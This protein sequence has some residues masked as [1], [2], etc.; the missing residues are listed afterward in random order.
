VTSISQTALRRIIDDAQ[1]DGIGLLKTGMFVEDKT[2]L[3]SLL[4]QL[5]DAQKDAVLD[6]ATEHNLWPQALSL[7]SYLKPDMQILMS[8]LA[9][10]QP[11]KVLEKL[12]R[13]VYEQ[14]NWQP[15]FLALSVMN[16]AN[17]KRNASLPALQEPEI[18]RRLVQ[19][20]TDCGMKKEIAPLLSYLSAEQKA[21]LA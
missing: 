14:D 6:A 3:D 20:A 15:L 2:L 7:I 11:K 8:N 21:L 13:T 9:G 12:L 4:R 19:R 10:Q 5:S 17:L 18:L 16:E 1:E